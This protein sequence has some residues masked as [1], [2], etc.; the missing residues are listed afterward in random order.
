[1]IVN[2]IE[3]LES[4]GACA[5]PE[6]PTQVQE[7]AAALEFGGGLREV[8]AEAGE[9]SGPP[10]LRLEACEALEPPKPQWDDAAS[11]LDV[12]HTVFEEQAKEAEDCMQYYREIIDKLL[13][14]LEAS[15]PDTDGL[16]TKIP[17][18]LKKKL[19][20]K[21]GKA[22]VF[23]TSPSVGCRWLPLFM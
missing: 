7:W 2:I 3:L 19:S 16:V 21:L 12:R 15:Q 8:K 4:Q 13:D 20:T 22:R 18:T 10:S 1:M 14:M 17:E 5:R 23:R 11:P 6:G 9:I